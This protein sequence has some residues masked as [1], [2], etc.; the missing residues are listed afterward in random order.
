MPRQLNI[1]KEGEDEDDR[2]EED[3]DD[4]DEDEKEEKKDWRGMVET[5]AGH[6]EGTVGEKS[7]MRLWANHIR[8]TTYRSGMFEMVAN[9]S[10]VPILFYL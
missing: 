1:I 2:E 9:H 10:K 7:F 3:D 5:L 6:W 4:E 8:S